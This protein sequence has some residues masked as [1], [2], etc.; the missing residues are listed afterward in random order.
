MTQGGQVSSKPGNSSSTDEA[1]QFGQSH[2]EQ[3]DNIEDFAKGRA[4]NQLNQR[5]GGL[6]S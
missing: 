6:V 1:D 2:P 5:W 3:W 4:Q